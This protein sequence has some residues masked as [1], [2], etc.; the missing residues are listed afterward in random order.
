MGDFTI[1]S[2]DLGSTLGFAI[3]KNGVIVDSGEVTLSGAGTHP[4]HRWIRFQNWLAK[5]TDVNAILYEEVQA[6][7]GSQAAMVYGALRA[8]VQIFSLAHRIPMSTMTPGDIKGDFTGN[9]NAPKE[10]VCNVAMNL[11]WKKGVRDTRNLNNEADAIALLWCVY[12]KREISP[13]FSHQLDEQ[14]R[15]AVS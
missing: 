15:F 3:G 4:G 9:G 12:V 5:F 10:L 2:L 14:P 8:Q 1:L 11:G 6:F 13:V 7:R